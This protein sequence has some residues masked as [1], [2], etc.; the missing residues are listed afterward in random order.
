MIRSL[1]STQYHQNF[2]TLPRFKK[3]LVA[4]TLVAS[5]SLVFSGKILAQIQSLYNPTTEEFAGISSLMSAV[6]NNDVN[7]A[8]FFSKA[9][10]LV[11][12]Q[13]NKGGATALHIASR[14]GNL[15]IVKILV[16]NGANLNIADAEGYTPI[17]RAAIVGNAAVVEFLLSKGAKAGLINTLNESA[18]I[19]AVQ[20]KCND[21][22]NLIIDKG[23]LINTMDILVLKG[24]SLMLF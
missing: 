12:N 18:L 17:M 4:L 5:F 16:E 6:A 10:A 2:F 15:D 24:R 7:G 9:G 8:K 22:L 19:H 3:S 20:S 21:C 1:N 14:E 23:N 11:I 13:R